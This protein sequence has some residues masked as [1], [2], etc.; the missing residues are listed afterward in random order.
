VRQLTSR[1]IK[2]T[3]PQSP[4][5]ARGPTIITLPD[6]PPRAELTP[7]NFRVPPQFHREFKLYAV[8]HDMS[9]VQLL[10]EAFALVKATRKQ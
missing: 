6:I 7:L 8:E 3:K 10:Q 9:M 5:S 2:K 1:R 4:D